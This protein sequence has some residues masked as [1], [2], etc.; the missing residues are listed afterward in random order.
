MGGSLLMLLAIVVV[1]VAGGSNT[2]NYDALLTR[3][4]MTV[5]GQLWLFGAFFFAFAVKSP[6][7]PF[8]TWLPDAQHE[9][10]TTAAVALS[11]KVGTYGIL[12]F[13]M[14][15]FPAAALDPTMRTVIIALSLIGIIYGALV[16]MV[17]PDF[18]KLVSYAS[19][20]HLGFVTLGLFALTVQS[21]QGALMVMVNSGIS[22]AALF[23]LV[24]MLHDRRKT[25]MIHN[26][27]GIARVVPLFAA[28]LTLVSL[29]SIGLPGTV[30]FV[31]EFLVLIGTYATFPWAAIVATTGVVFAA[32]YLLWAIQ[33][34]IF[35]PLSNPENE[36]LPD[37]NRREL[38]VMI[39]FAV[40]IVWLGI[41]PGPVLSRME[42]ASARVVEQVRRGAANPL[43]D[44]ASV[45]SPSSTP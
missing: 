31:G 29:S 23:I 4:N 20:S 30:G 27:G 34:I 12:R 11:L 2:F 18:K 35:N 16:A 14:P 5:V 36:N 1:W 39:A 43:A 38:G 7:F 40:I 6:L 3:M 41:T 44:P 28:A 19:I 32:I 26:F 8:H 10:P 13:A 42:G 22:T 45:P 17:Q 33:R 25:G 9:A 24:G 15:F 21:V 37:L